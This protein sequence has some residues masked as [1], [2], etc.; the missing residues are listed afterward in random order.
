MKSIGRE[1]AIFAADSEQWNL[2]KNTYLLGGLMSILR[3]KLRLLIKEKVKRDPLG[4][5]IVIKLQYNTRTLAIIN[6][7]CLPT[8]SL[9][10]NVCSLTQYN[11]KEGKVKSTNKYRKEIFT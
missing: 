5:L 4:N 3:G 8:T 9:N 1:V 6:L 7:Y 10:S 2:A 11:L